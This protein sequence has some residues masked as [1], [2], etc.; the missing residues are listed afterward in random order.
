M[1]EL[2]LTALEA[3]FRLG[4]APLSTRRDVAMLGLIHRTQ[5][6]HGPSQFADFFCPAPSSMG[7]PRTRRIANRHGRQIGV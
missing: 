1:R 7:T 2:S 6:G 4:L 3:L 5:L